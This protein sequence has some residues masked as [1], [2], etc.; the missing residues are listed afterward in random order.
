MAARGSVR[1]SPLL[2]SPLLEKVTSRS[3]ARAYSLDSKRWTKN[4]AANHY[5]H[6]RYWCGSRRSGRSWK[7]TFERRTWNRTRSLRL[8]TGRKNPLWRR[9]SNRSQNRSSAA[10]ARYRASYSTYRARYAYSYR[11]RGGLSHPGDVGHAGLSEL[12]SAVFR[13]L[14]FRS[15]RRLR[16]CPRVVGLIALR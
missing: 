9:R 13:D 8:T 12:E 15:R 11:F 10:T 7:K 4:S 5:C 6:R 14:G 2:L 3:A 16:R 1:V